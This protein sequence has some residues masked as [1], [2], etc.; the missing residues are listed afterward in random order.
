MDNNKISKVSYFKA[1]ANYYNYGEWDEIISFLIEFLNKLETS[2]KPYFSEIKKS[3]NNLSIE[4][5]D[6]AD[7]ETV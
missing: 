2:I 1:G 3:L 4:T 6:L 7:E 5:N